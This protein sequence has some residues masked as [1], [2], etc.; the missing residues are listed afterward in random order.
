MS[1]D[2]D[3]TRTAAPADLADG[4]TGPE[5]P[6]R[7]RTRYRFGDEVGRGGIGRVTWARDQELE[8][9]VGVKELL[10]HSPGHQAR[11]VREAMITARLQHPSIVPVYEAGRWA[12]G[13][14]FYA[15]KMV[16]GR[17]L[18]E[19]VKD[20]DTYE[21]YAEYAYSYGGERFAGERVSICSG[22]DNIGDYQVTIGRRLQQRAASQ[23]PIIVHVDPDAPHHSI[24]DRDL[25]WSLVGF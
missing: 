16:T 14:P 5:L 6:E 17:S 2:H 7:Q 15:M 23:A 25:R 8:R 9:D 22:G 4:A 13:E 24:I 11:F 20:A 3:E 18:K 1:N 12:N 21:A 10:R 19:L